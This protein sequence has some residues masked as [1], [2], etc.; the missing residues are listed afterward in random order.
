MFPV[1]F[2]DGAGGKESACLPMQE[3]RDM[4]SILGLEIS[5][6]GG[7]SYPIQYSCLESFMDRTELETTEAT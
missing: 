4:G 7:H 6:G 5:T 3:T 1:N 2:P